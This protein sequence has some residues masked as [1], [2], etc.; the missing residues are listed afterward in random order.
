[1]NNVKN[2]LNGWKRSSNGEFFGVATGFA[3][4]KNLPVDKTRLVF[5]LFVLV[6]GGFGLIAYIL[7]AIFLPSDGKVPGADAYETEY[8][9][10]KED[11]EREKAKQAFRDKERDWDERMKNS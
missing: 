6:T 10:V 4:W 3:E 9:D 8:T 2:P 1:M 11:S 5:L 7:L